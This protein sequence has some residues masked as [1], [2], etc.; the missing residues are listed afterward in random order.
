MRDDAV[1]RK[2]RIWLR[3]LDGRSRSARDFEDLKIEEGISRKTLRRDLEALARVPEAQILIYFRNNSVFYRIDAKFTYKGPKSRRCRACK[4]LK[5]ISEYYASRNNID[6]LNNTCIE[7]HKKAVY[8]Y[9]SK[10]RRELNKY[11]RSWW[12]KNAI[13]INEIRRE[14]YKESK[15]I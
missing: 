9:Q 13:K 8:S 14:R 12:K 6:G 2:F 4:K 10:N 11:R 7:C 3:L 5:D 15:L 1:V